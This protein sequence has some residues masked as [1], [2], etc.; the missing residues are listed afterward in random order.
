[1]YEKQDHFFLNTAYTAVT[2][3]CSC[4]RKHFSVICRKLFKHQ[5]TCISEWLP[6]NLDPRQFA[7]NYRPMRHKSEFEVY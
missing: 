3:V 7:K 6:N 5:N 4:L 2:L 1:M